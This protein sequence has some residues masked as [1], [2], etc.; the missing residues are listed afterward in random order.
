VVGASDA[1]FFATPEYNSSMPG[2]LKNALDW[3]SRPRATN[4]LRARPVAVIA[5]TT[6]LVLRYVPLWL[7]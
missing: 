4:V 3:L 6:G 1:V 5:A 2:A 7:R